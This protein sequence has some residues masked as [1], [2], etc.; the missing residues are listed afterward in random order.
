MKYFEWKRKIKPSIINLLTIMQFANKIDIEFLK[1]YCL[2]YSKEFE[3]IYPNLN[4]K[5]EN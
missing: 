2:I 3:N 1:F 5:M 4:K